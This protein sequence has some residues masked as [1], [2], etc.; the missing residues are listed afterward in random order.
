[1]KQFRTVLITGAS[2]GIGA[3]LAVH[4]AA[5]GITLYLTGRDGHRLSSV[6]DM[7][8]LRGAQVESG[9][10]DVRNKAAMAEWLLG[11]DARAPVDLVIANAGISGGTGGGQGAAWIEQE[12]SIFEVNL[13]GALNTIQPLIPRMIHRRKGQIALMSS[14]A[15]FSG[16]PGAPAYSA[17]K[18]GIRIYGEALRGSLM[19][20]EI[21]V[22]VICPGFIVSPM[23]AVNGYRMPFLMPADKAAHIIARA[24]SKNRARICFPWPTAVVAMTLGLVPPAVSSYFLSKLPAKPSLQES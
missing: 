11:V 22:S 24:L 5:R 23:T 10:I 8:R 13:M 12:S 16:W 19:P 2:S 9:L 17:S 6:A 7:C 4:Y 15:A 18:A 3:A 1:M 20:Y 14:L 21:G